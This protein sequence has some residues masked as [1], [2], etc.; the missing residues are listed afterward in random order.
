[1]KSKIKIFRLIIPTIMSA[2]IFSC[3]N[4]QEKQRKQD[5]EMVK[6]RDDYYSNLLEKQKETREKRERTKSNQ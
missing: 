4:E 3:E 5:L 6:I 2:F 1:M